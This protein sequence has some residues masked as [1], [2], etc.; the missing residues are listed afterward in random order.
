MRSEKTGKL[1]SITVLAFMAVFLT[2]SLGQTQE[3][4]RSKKVDALRFSVLNSS[5][6]MSRPEEIERGSLFLQGLRWGDWSLGVPFSMGFD[7]DLYTGKWSLDMGDFYGRR[8]A[9]PYGPLG[10]QIGRT[11]SFGNQSMSL[12][13]DFGW[14]VLRPGDTRMRDWVGSMRIILLFPEK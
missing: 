13:A 12:S 9:L 6:G 5:G 8:D 1:V 11:L 10:L 7:R 3:S 2:A 14:T 4:G